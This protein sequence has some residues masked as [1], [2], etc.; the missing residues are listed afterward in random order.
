MKPTNSL[1]DAMRVK[2]KLLKHKQL[3]FPYLVKLC[4]KSPHRL[5]QALTQLRQDGHTVNCIMSGH[6]EGRQVAYELVNPEN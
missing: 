1:Y 5:R 3:S 6:G 4:G 2:E